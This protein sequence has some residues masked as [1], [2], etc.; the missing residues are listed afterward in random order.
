MYVFAYEIVLS[1]DTKYSAK[2]LRGK[3]NDTYSNGHQLL[4]R[5]AGNFGE[6]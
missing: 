2:D 4:Y 5:I 1:T 3:K 6:H